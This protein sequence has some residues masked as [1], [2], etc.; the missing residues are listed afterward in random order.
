M[1]NQPEW[2]PVSG[3]NMR[4]LVRG[5]FHYIAGPDAREELYDIAADP[6]ESRDLTRDAAM[7]DTLGALRSAIAAFPA[8]DR[9][10]R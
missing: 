3:G 2:Y 1:R 6:F 5:R 7:A 4:S 8:A 10:G 9:G